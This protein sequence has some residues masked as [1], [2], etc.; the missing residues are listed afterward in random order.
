MAVAVGGDGRIFVA[1]AGEPGKEG[2]GRVVVIDKGKVA[3]FATGLDD[4]RGIAFT[5]GSLYVADVKRVWKIDKAGKAF[6][7]DKEAA[8][9]LLRM[10]DHLKENQVPLDQTKCRV[11]KMLKIDAKNESFVDN[12][13]ANA[14]LTRE[15]RKGFEVP[16]KL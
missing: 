1:E 4:P 12:K 3:P 11:G 6:A 9:T 8:E 2:E 10:E 16:A 5:G 7:G 14:M 15:Y 13:Q